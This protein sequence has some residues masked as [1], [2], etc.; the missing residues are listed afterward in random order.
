MT[1]DA[2]LLDVL[3]RFARTL[4]RDYRV[5]DV[6]PQLC[7]DT[8]RLLGVDGAGV[9]LEDEAGVLRFV[10]ASDELVEQIEQLQIATGEGPC[11]GAYEQGAPV[12]IPDLAATAMLPDFAPRALSA[13]I[14]AVFSFPLRVEDVH[15]GAINLYSAEAGPLRDDDLHAAQVLADLATTYI[16][17]ANAVDRSSL[18]AAQLQRALDTR[19]VVE[20]AKG[21]LA[22]AWDVPV[23]TA[24]ARL[25]RYARARRARLHD[26]AADVIDGRLDPDRI[27]EGSD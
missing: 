22:A 16:V 7:T 2:G 18:L 17:S 4:V 25:R 27:V 26:I 20:Q 10:A 14:R 13:G 9:M 5:P 3:L 6:L 11:I 1:H 21:K 24:F 23:D 12:V 8:A 15:V 19:V